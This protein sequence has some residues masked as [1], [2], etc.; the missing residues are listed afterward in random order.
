[1]P[2]ILLTAGAKVI[3]DG[4]W[5]FLGK[6]ERVNMAKHD[7]YCCL[8][9]QWDGFCDVCLPV[10]N[11]P[12]ACT[13]DHLQSFGCMSLLSNCFFSSFCSWI[14]NWLNKLMCLEH[15]I[16]SMVYP[17]PNV[18]FHSH[19]VLSESLSWIW[20]DPTGVHQHIQ[21]GVWWPNY[22][23]WGWDSTVSPSW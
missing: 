4:S 21:C 1:V 14:S 8:G 10:K 19:F 2:S 23:K 5:H 22:R 12:R 16:W 18:D 9:R 20:S 3:H 13:A 7:Y 15:K 11:L 6:A 17:S